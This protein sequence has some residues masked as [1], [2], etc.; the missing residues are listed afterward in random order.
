MIVKNT[1]HV[2]SHAVPLVAMLSTRDT[3]L[4]TGVQLSN[5]QSVIGGNT[6]PPIVQ[7][8]L[9]PMMSP[10]SMD[11]VTSAGHT[12]PSL[13]KKSKI[14][15]HSGSNVG[16]VVS[17]T[18]MICTQVL[19]LSQISVA[20]QVR[21]MVISCGHSPGAIASVDV[22]IIAVGAWQSSVAVATPVL[23]GRLE[24]SQ[25]MVTSTGQVITGATSS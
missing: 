7:P 20:V 25:S 10:T 5:R 6:C 8:S 22:M 13:V 16:G 18:V 15:W 14:T 17:W 19:E 9:M 24:A 21:V 4:S 3:R 12:A 2:E 1:V 11:T 23:A